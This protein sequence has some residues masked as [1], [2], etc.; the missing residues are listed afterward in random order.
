M[1]RRPIYQQAMTPAERQKRTRE[2]RAATIVAE[3][4]LARVHIAQAR[5]LA[6]ASREGMTDNAGWLEA[7]ASEEAMQH[8]TD[9]LARLIE[10]VRA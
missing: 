9:A 4:E 1:S 7:K 3:A 2:L 6:R 10:S 5:R 8:A